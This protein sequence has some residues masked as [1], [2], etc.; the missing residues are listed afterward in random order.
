MS[1]T[2]DHKNTEMRTTHVQLLS[3]L[4]HWIA[5]VESDQEP[6]PYLMKE[7]LRLLLTDMS[8]LRAEYKQALK[9]ACGLSYPK[10]EIILELFAHKVRDLFSG[11]ERTQ[12]LDSLEQSKRA[13]AASTQ[14]TITK[15]A[16]GTI[17][18]RRYRGEDHV[19]TFTN[20][21]YEYKG[22]RFRSATEVARFISGSLYS[23]P[24]FFNRKSEFSMMQK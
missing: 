14:G 8:M 12:P 3:G 6:T 21:F 17:I 4:A 2:A 7:L 5:G 20:G 16:E 13:I 11:T 19:V 10:H 18:K 24:Q 23:G 22:Q 1:S 15:L 9:R